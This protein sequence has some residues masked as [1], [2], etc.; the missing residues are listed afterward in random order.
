MC[1]FFICEMNFYEIS[2]IFN[3]L[4]LL[5]LCLSITSHLR[6]PYAFDPP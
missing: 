5:H 6:N 3:T 1:E 2:V 4:Q